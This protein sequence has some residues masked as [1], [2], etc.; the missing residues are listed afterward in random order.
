MAG[1]LLT[2]IVDVTVGGNP[3]RQHADFAERSPAEESDSRGHSYAYNAKSK[4]PF[5]EECSYRSRT[6][7]EQIRRHF[8]L[9]REILSS[10]SD[11]GKPAGEARTTSRAESAW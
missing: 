10:Y 9:Y 11:D 6:E 8:K 5:G 1:L 7:D 4:Y 3:F 2:D